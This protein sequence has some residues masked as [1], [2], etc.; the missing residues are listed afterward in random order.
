MNT[1]IHTVTDFRDVDLSSQPTK[2]YLKDMFEEWIE[3]SEREMVSSKMHKIWELNNLYYESHMV[4]V[5][6][7]DDHLANF[8]YSNS[9]RIDTSQFE[10]RRIK[11]GKWKGK[12]YVTKNMITDVIDRQDARFADAERRMEVETDEDDR[13]DKIEIVIERYLNKQERKHQLWDEVHY[14][15]IQQRNR[16]G[17]FWTQPLWNRRLNYAQ[18]D[19]EW[20][21]YHPQDVL[22]DPF[23]TLKYFL[24]ARYI[25]IKQRVE[26]NR[27]KEYLASFGIKPEDVVADEDYFEYNTPLRNR[28]KNAQGSSKKGLG[29]FVTLYY[30][31]F[32]ETYVDRYGYPGEKGQVEYEHTFHFTAV[33][34]KKHGVLDLRINKYADPTRRI[35]WQFSAMPWYKKLSNI[36]LYPISDIEPL[37]KIQDI[38]N[39][40]YTLKLDSAMKQNMV[41]AFIKGKLTDKYKRLVD[42]FLN[43]TGGMFP[44]ESDDDLRKAVVPFELAGMDKGVDEF[45]RAMEESFRDQK[46]SNEITGGRMPDTTRKYLSG[47]TIKQVRAD[48]FQRNQ[49]DELS[50]NWAVSQESRRI[51]SIL[52]IEKK[53]KQWVDI[54]DR[55]TKEKHYIPVNTTWTFAEYNAYLEKEFPELV[56]IVMNP[57]TGQEEKSYLKASAKFSEDNWVKTRYMLKDPLTGRELE[58]EEIMSKG[59]EVKV[60]HLFDSDGDKHNVEIKIT[61][62][63]GFKQDEEAFKTAISELINRYP[64]ALELVRIHLKKL[65]GE[66]AQKADIVINEIRASNQIVSM[67]TEVIKRGPEFIQ[68]ITELMQKFDLLQSQKGTKQQKQLAA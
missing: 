21:S 32:K 24:D 33:Y 9:G 46:G 68:A 19:I 63:F 47:E 38:I 67:G 14:P 66:A 3:A 20:R 28:A 15:A 30:P 11:T 58:Y 5:G 34:H 37:R 45:T 49:P 25:I 62:D 53:G 4:P 50:V 39:I 60:N 16:L 12:V 17:L 43:V 64:E 23:P 56:E 54:E 2:D 40:G 48:D 36:R 44:I 27:A 55:D 35:G 42:D 18:G 1:L 31:E 26:I 7:S 59:S 41:R 22:I 61:F 52:A 10:V 6:W 29:D 51:Y 13:N 8:I 57:F 65:G